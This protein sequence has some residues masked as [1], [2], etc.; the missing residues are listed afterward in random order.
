MDRTEYGNL[1]FPFVAVL[2]FDQCLLV[3]P[4]SSFFQPIKSQPCCSRLLFPL[5]LC[6]VI[7][8]PAQS[9]VVCPSQPSCPCLCRVHLVFVH[10]VWEQ[11]HPLNTSSQQP[12]HKSGGI[13]IWTVRWNF[14]FPY[15]LP[16][17]SF[18]LSCWSLTKTDGDSHF[19]SS[20]H[21]VR[22]S[23]KEN[24]VRQLKLCFAP[25]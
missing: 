17:V 18:P 9:Q 11:A 15:L 20:S 13:F 3:T 6:L 7:T 16:V 25:K 21:H 10:S 5:T 19:C 24:Q 12:F 8:L 2:S 14:I 1:V 22:Q 4:G 23:F